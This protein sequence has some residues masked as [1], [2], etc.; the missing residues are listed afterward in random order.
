MITADFTAIGFRRGRS[1]SFN[2]N[3]NFTELIAGT[4]FLI[5]VYFT[6]L[7]SPRIILRSLICKISTGD[8]AVKFDRYQLLKST[9]VISKGNLAINVSTIICKLCDEPTFFLWIVSSAA[10]ISLTAWC[11]S[12]HKYKHI[13]KRKQRKIASEN[14]G[15]YVHRTANFPVGSFMI[16]TIP[17]M[18]NS[19]KERKFQKPQTNSE[20]FII[21]VSSASV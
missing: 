9:N 16:Y 13:V 1:F 7:R 5:S 14:F 8:R 3:M 6:Q 15:P 4:C 20:K 11:W 17:A 10:T 21:P 12:I 19:G 18:S 2:C